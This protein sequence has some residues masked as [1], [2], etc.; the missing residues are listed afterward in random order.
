MKEKGIDLWTR[1]IKLLVLLVAIALL[2]WTQD[3]RINGVR[4]GL[5]NL[6]ILYAGLAMVVLVNG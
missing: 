5:E 6:L 4:Y 1:R 2:V 3:I